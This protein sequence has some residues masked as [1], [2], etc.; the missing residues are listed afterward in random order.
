MTFLKTFIVTAANARGNRTRVG[1]VGVPDL[2]DAL[3]TAAEALAKAM[4]TWPARID[5]AV[6]LRQA[7]G[8]AGMN[9]ARQREIASKGGRAAHLKGTAHQ[10]TSAEARDAGKAGG[11]ISRGSRGRLPVTTEVPGG[12]AE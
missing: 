3:A 11:R 6:R 8:F 12:E 7:H 1:T 2:D 5:I 4:V 10:W 9:P